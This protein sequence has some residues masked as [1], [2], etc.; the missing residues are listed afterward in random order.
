MKKNLLAL[1]LLCFCY[2]SFSQSLPELPLKKN[3]INYEFEVHLENKN[4]SLEEYFNLNYQEIFSRFEIIINPEMNKRKISINDSGVY[5]NGLSFSAGAYSGLPG[6]FQL[7]ISGSGAKLIDFT[8]V[9]LLSGSVKKRA[10]MNEVRAET[11]MIYTSKNSYSLRLKKF[12]L[13]ITY[14]DMTNSVLD[15]S[16]YYLKLKEKN[17]ISKAEV[18][19][20]IQIDE[21]IKILNS[22]LKD[23]FKYVIDNE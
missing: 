6:V 15:L 1:I 21:V 13:N 16:E 9:G 11:E 14:M 20:L 8:I 18:K 10:L 2:I 7:I 3:K 12:T 5:P 23:S 19:L 22:A 17:K 4:K